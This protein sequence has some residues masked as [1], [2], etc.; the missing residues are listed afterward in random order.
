MAFSLTC[1]LKTFLQFEKKNTAYYYFLKNY[2]KE[3][4]KQNNFREKKLKNS[5]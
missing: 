3:N 1:L 5:I 2:E 4:H